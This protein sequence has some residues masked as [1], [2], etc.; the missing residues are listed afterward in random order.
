MIQHKIGYERRKKMKI[1]KSQLKKPLSLILT[2]RD[3]KGFGEGIFGDGK[4]IIFRG[5]GH[6]S[7]VAYHSQS[8]TYQAGE[9]SAGVVSSKFYDLFGSEPSDSFSEIIVYC[10]RYGLETSLG[11][12]HRLGK[13][14]SSKLTLV[15]CGCDID[16]K[17]EHARKLG[18]KF[19]RS[20]C[21]G[22]ETLAD[23]ATSIIKK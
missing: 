5:E 19:I 12:V 9:Y 14:H 4:L 20:E 11:L 2:Y 1:D 8:E 6:Y 13:D 21:G 10:G 3:V 7:P 16:K 17:I 23:I 18:I 22:E 15:G